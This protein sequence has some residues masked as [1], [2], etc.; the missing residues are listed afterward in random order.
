MI[1]AVAF[2]LRLPRRPLSLFLRLSSPLLLLLMLLM[3]LLLL[4]FVTAAGAQ[5]VGQFFQ[6]L[7]AV[8]LDGFLLLL[9]LRLKLSGD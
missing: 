7:L 1:I 5:G 2:H 3:M 4:L 9:Q 8:I 6:R